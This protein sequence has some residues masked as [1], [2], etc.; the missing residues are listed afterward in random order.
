MANFSPEYMIKEGQTPLGFQGLWDSDNFKPPELSRWSD[1]VYLSWKEE[2]TEDQRANLN[3][4]VQH[5]IMNM[6]TR[7]SKSSLV[8]N[9]I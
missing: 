6:E 1:I 4:I 2:S 7:N 9:T 8:Y 3:K 5:D